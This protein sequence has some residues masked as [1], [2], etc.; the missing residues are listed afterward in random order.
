MAALSSQIPPWGDVVLQL[1]VAPTPM[2]MGE[3]G[4]GRGTFSQ[5]MDRDLSLER[6][7]QAGKSLGTLGMG[8]MSKF[9]VGWGCLGMMI[10]QSHLFCFLVRKIHIS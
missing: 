9:S 7:S 2:L 1:H 6:I 10:P 5:E 4:K 8:K 3:S